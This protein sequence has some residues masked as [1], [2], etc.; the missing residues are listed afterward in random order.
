MG[1]A[2]SSIPTEVPSS[3]VASPDA[4]FPPS[5]DNYSASTLGRPTVR[6]VPSDPAFSPPLPAFSLPS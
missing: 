6:K 1:L 2:G 4:V 5:L 3:P